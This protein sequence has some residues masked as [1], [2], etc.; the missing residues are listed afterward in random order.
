MPEP[1]N[2]PTPQPPRDAA[3]WAKPMSELK[4]G[5]V[6]PEAMNLNVEGR[7]TVGPLMGFGQLWQKPIA[8]GWALGSHLS[9]ASRCGRRTCH[10]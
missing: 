4:V 1:T 10:P 3:Y 7:Q 9:S 8:S 6:S 5:D 2:S